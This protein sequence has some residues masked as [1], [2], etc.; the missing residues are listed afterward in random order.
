MDRIEVNLKTKEI[1]KIA[2]TPEE[3]ET[4]NKNKAAWDAKEKEKKAK[5][6]ENVFCGLSAE[7]A[8]QV[9][10]NSPNTIKACKDLMK[11]MLKL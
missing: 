3:I 1:K 9:I 11:E 4:A 7:E 2:L 5:L 10:E 6:K 8:A